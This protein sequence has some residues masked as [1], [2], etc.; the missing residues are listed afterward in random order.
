MSF[1][2]FLLEVSEKYRLFYRKKREVYVDGA[3]IKSPLP[4]FDVIAICEQ[5]S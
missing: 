1:Q 3:L 5:L 2:P 4:A